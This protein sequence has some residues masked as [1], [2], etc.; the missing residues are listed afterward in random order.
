MR[1]SI[2]QREM[3]G[4]RGGHGCGWGSP[5]CCIQLTENHWWH[6]EHCDDNLQPTFQL[7][8]R[9][10]NIYQAPDILSKTYTW[11]PRL[12]IRAGHQEW[13][14]SC[15][16]L[17]QWRELDKKQSQREIN[18]ISMT[19]T[20]IVDFVTSSE[21]KTIL[22]FIL[23]TTKCEKNIRFFP[24]ILLQNTLRYLP[25]PLL[26]ACPCEAPKHWRKSH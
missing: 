22:Y 11:N 2:S 3:M 23:G 26:P 16:S 10:V 4:M 12:C 6:G 18:T 15:S 1:S 14:M 19:F 24:P 7:V 25:H 21:H 20:F 13:S 9:A 5:V 17:L 8:C